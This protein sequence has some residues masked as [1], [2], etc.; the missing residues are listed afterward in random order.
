MSNSPFQINAMTARCVNAFVTTA[1]RVSHFFDF[2]LQ[3]SEKTTFGHVDLVESQSYMSKLFPVESDYEDALVNKV[4]TNI[5]LTFDALKARKDNP[6]DAI[7]TA[8]NS[9]LALINA[10]PA[11]SNLWATPSP[12]SAEEV[13][14]N[15]VMNFINDYSTMTINH[16][17][18]IGRILDLSN[19]SLAWPSSLKMPNLMKVLLSGI[20]PCPSKLPMSVTD[21][22]AAF[23]GELAYGTYPAHALAAANSGFTTQILID[24]LPNGFHLRHASSGPSDAAPL[25]AGDVYR[26]LLRL[27]PGKYIINWSARQTGTALVGN[28]SFVTGAADGVFTDNMSLAVLG[29]TYTHGETTLNLPSGGPLWYSV[30]Q[31][32]AVNSVFSLEICA[33]VTRIADSVG[34]LDAVNRLQSGS[35]LPVDETF[36]QSLAVVDTLQPSMNVIREYNTYRIN[37]SQEDVMTALFNR[38]SDAKV[39]NFT[40]TDPDNIYSLLTVINA[41]SSAQF[42]VNL[43]YFLSDFMLIELASALDPRFSVAPPLF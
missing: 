23:S 19:I 32:A 7:L 25:P 36:V 33:I 40:G 38:L 13:D 42:K 22:L 8:I 21:N 16:A 5:L 37:S 15:I 18:A 35:L 17:T 3:M 34:V 43:K 30:N 14:Y 28:T 11:S 41:T 12:L 4:S 20:S 29:S 27:P 39:S 10:R 9:L 24:P 1:S 26:P 2:A 31:T 6:S